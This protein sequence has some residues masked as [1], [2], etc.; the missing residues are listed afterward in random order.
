MANLATWKAGTITVPS[1]PGP[2]T[3]TI[4][5][6]PRGIIFFGANWLLED[7]VDTGFGS[8]LFRG[9][10]APNYSNPAAL[11][12]NAAAAAQ[13]GDQHMIDNYAIL[14]MTRA[15]SATVL[16]RAAV[17]SFNSDG[18]TVN[19]DVGVA[20]GYKVIYVVLIDVE[21]CVGI[22]GLSSVNP[23]IGFKAGA[24]LIH[25]AWAGPVASG[26][27]RVQ[28]WY[29][30]GAYRGA[31]TLAWA[32]AGLTCFTFPSAF[33]GQYNINADE[34]GPHVEICQG[35]SFLGPFL[36]TS[37]ITAFPNGVNQFD[38]LFTGDGTNG[39]MAMVWDDEDST[40]GFLTLA[41]SS[42]GVATVAGLPFPPGLVLGYSLSN[43]PAGQNTGARGAIGFSVVTEDF[44]W[45]AL[46]DVGAPGYQPDKG[47]FQ[48]FQRGAVDCVHNSTVHDGSMVLTDDGFEVTTEEDSAAPGLWIWHAFGHPTGGWIPSLYRWQIDYRS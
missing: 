10:C 29:G 24:A 14:N 47:S 48:S 21:N 33:G 18:F 5:A 8:A 34:F 17:T 44:Q 37:N 16:Y 45:A 39:G 28:E 22:V 30:G 26:S 12:Q 4:G 25:G 20:G 23:T 11:L 13:A 40:T 7:A 43:E 38:F 32:S 1:S 27:D 42:G 2:V 36:I 9:M 46:V 3:V 6:Q 31:S 15:G 19:F 41:T 35:G